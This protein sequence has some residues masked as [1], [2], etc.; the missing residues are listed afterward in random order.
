MAAFPPEIVKMPLGR[1]I[2]LKSMR[3]LRITESEKERF[4][5]YYFNGLREDPFEM[6]ERII[7]PS[8]KV[9]T[10]DKQPEMSAENIT[11]SLISGASSMEYKLIV[12]NYPNADMVGH[13]GNIEA[14]IKGIETVDKQVGKLAGFSLPRNGALI[15]TADHGNAEEMINKET[16]DVDTEH[17]TYPVPFIVVANRFLGKSHTVQSGILAD[18]APTILHLLGV[19]APGTMTG[20]I[21]IQ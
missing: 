5:T 9:S 12:V 1:V 3:Q 8:P 20:R 7:I 10:Y 2:S 6:E 21:L 14:A 19:D 4:V 18:V 11:N 13:T 16:G 17:S 15:I